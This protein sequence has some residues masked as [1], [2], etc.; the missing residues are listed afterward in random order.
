MS[1]YIRKF[2]ASDLKAFTPIEPLDDGDVMTEEFVKCI[3]KSELAVTGIR[4]GEIVGCGG[5]HPVLDNPED[6]EFW[7]RLSQDCKKHPY[8]TIKWLQD[9]IEIIKKTYPFKFLRATMRGKFKAGIKLVKFLGFTFDKKMRYN[10]EDWFV[11]ELKCLP[12]S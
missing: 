2:K 1:V 11:W 3:E 4:N 12:S 6:G 10:N 7:L 5:V 9:G 8:D